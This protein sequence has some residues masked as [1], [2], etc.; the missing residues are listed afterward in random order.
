MLK[1]EIGR[2]QLGA[3]SD[4]LSAD[5][6][7][8]FRISIFL[9]SITKSPDRS[10]HAHRNAFGINSVILYTVLPYLCTILL[11]K[12]FQREKSMISENE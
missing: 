12:L 10:T 7:A 2:E 1:A 11:C 5:F 6:S 4:N 3:A 8:C 9:S